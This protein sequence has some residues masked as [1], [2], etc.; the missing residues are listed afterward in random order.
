MST[1]SKLKIGLL[2]GTIVVVVALALIVVFRYPPD[3]AA[4]HTDVPAFD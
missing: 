4:T 1:S 3:K 2:V